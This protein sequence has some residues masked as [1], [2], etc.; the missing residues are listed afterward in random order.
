MLWHNAQQEKPPAG[1][2]VLTKD[3]EGRY[4]MS[5]WHVHSKHYVWLAAGVFR[6]AAEHILWWCFTEDL[7]QPEDERMN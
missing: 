6:I 2:W 4:G 7:P 3:Y 1:K 5:K